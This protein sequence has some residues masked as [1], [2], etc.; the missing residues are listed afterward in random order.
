M[1]FCRYSQRV[2]LLCQ[3]VELFGITDRL[4]RWEREVEGECWD[5]GIKLAFP[6]AFNFFLLRLLP[7]CVCVF[8]RSLSLLSVTE[9]DDHLRWL[10]E[11]C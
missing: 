4:T 7:C 9:C 5:E 6:S 2:V 11:W 1:K 3:L 8:S 10:K